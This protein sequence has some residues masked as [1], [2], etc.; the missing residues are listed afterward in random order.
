MAAAVL[1]I[2]VLGALA[3]TKLNPFRAGPRAAPPRRVAWI[4]GAKGVQWLGDKPRRNEALSLGRRLKL[5]R[6]LVEITYQT[7]ARV[8]L[9]GPAE[10]GV[11]GPS[12]GYLKL[13]KLVAR[14]EGRRAKGFTIET[15]LADVVDLGTEFGIEVDGNGAAEVVVLTG[16]VDVVSNANADRPAKRVRL[17][18]N[19]VA[20]VEDDSGAITRREKIDSRVVASYRKRLDATSFDTVSAATVYNGGS[21]DLDQAGSWTLGLPSSS[22][23]GLINSDGTLTAPFV[24][25]FG[26][27]TTDPTTLPAISILARTRSICTARQIR[28]TCLAGASQR[29]LRSFSINLHST[30][31]AARSRLGLPLSQTV[32]CSTF[33]VRP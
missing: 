4:S 23:D 6:G 10:Y 27:N 25:D 12:S 14:V 21:G 5:K 32:A 3:F 33:P 30:S 28:T 9:Q 15:P 11:Q 8:V 16:E 20:F 2:A 31:A 13:G 29:P 17:T 24:T 18:A 26:G 22:Q 19:Q 7:G 1:L